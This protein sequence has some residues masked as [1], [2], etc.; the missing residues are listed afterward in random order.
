MTIIL[1]RVE[2]SNIRSHKHVVFE[3][4]AE[5]ITAI[6]GPNGTGKSTIV[7]SIAWVLYGTKPTGVSKVSAIYREDALFGDDRCFAIVEIEV[8]NQYLKIERRMVNKNGAV[9]C[10]VWEKITAKD[11]T[12][13]FK[14]VAG[15]AVSHA[16]PYIRKRLRM[17]EKGFLSAILVQQKQVDQLISASPRERAQVIEK[18]TGISA[19]TAALV[20]SRQEFNSLKKVASISTVDESALAKLKMDRDELEVSIEKQTESVGEIRRKVS[21]LK[22]SGVELRDNVAE[23]SQKR[24]A[25]EDRREE[26][27][28]VS[29]KIESRESELE[30]LTEDRKAQRK[31]LSLISSGTS[32]DEIEPKVNG[33]KGDL[34]AKELQSAKIDAN[35]VKN[36][37]KLQEYSKTVEGS[38][39][40]TAE[41]VIVS[42]DAVQSVLQDTRDEISTQKASILSADSEMKKIAKAIS[43]LTGGDGTCPTCLQ[44]IDNVSAAVTVLDN[45]VT[46]LNKSKDDSKS[47]ILE[48]QE[49]ETSSKDSIAEHDLILEAI[50]QSATLAKLIEEDSVSYTTL[51]SDIITLESELKALEKVYNA[52]KRHED[53]KN[54]Y[55]RLLARSKTVS[56]EIEAL[57]G[58]KDEIEAELKNS[59]SISAAALAKLR[60]KLDEARAAHT[61]LMMTL[62]ESKGELNLANERLLHLHEK[63][64]KAEEEIKKYKDLL[65]SVEVASASTNLIEEFREERIRTSIPVIEVYASDL[66]SRFTEGKFTSLKIDGKFN[67]TV[68]LANGIER[69]VGLLSGG[70]LS[71]ASMALRLAISMLLNSGS[72]TN[73]IILD[74]VLVSQ[75]AGRAE[76]ILSTVKDVCKGQVV[77]IAHNDSIDGIADKVVE[78]SAS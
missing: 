14:Q 68:V 31:K 40:E 53:I 73:L 5:G 50:T 60:I 69:A 77:L 43:V 28:V 16:E 52:A 21:E 54:D 65:K 67:T 78:L 46:A 39:L 8:E 11:G 24:E 18:L 48:L 76:L 75:D 4:E 64:A 49:V 41:D 63:I 33:L 44:H 35:L 42:R 10:E 30:R 36:R 55:D 62:T 3:P 66:L 51:A 37:R 71:A 57:N 26:L 59:G 27:T 74:E 58:R 23:E 32:L 12:E 19:V 17:D 61:K 2:L 45:E 1:K 20:E 7:D 15:P 70:E 38:D 9:E 22:K 25:A 6:S 72:S 34:R 13:K 56:D 47:K 29:T